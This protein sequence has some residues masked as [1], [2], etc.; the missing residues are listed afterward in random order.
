M[1]YIAFKLKT[2]SFGQ[3]RSKQICMSKHHIMEVANAL[4]QL[5]SVPAQMARPP[6]AAAWPSWGPK[7]LAHGSTLG[8]CSRHC[9][10]AVFKPSHHPRPH[11]LSGKGGG[12]V[13]VECLCVRAHTGSKELIKPPVVYPH[14]ALDPLTT[15]KEKLPKQPKNWPKTRNRTRNSRCKW[16]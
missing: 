1:H 4:L 14:F 8:H 11:T 15:W 2:N 13:G 3:K 10:L 16:P 7:I 9:R 6:H 5:V 12:F